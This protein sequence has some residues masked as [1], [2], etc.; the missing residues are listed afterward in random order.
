MEVELALRQSL[1][2]IL[3]WE[4]PR[5]GSESKITDVT[6]HA[7]LSAINRRI[8]N[9]DDTVVANKAMGTTLR[10]AGCKSQPEY[11]IR[12]ISH[13]SDIL[14]GSEA[15]GTENS[16]FSALIQ[17]L[18]LCG[19]S[20]L[21][22][23]ERG[24][25]R[26]DCAV[27]GIVSCWDCLQVCAVYLM[28]DSF[29]VIIW[30]SPPLMIACLQDRIDLA[31][32]VI[33]LADF[34]AKTIDLLKTSTLVAAEEVN[35]KLSSKIFFKKVR[36]WAAPKN[37]EHV[38]VVGH[39]STAHFGLDMMMRVYQ[40]LAD[41]EGAEKYILFPCGIIGNPTAR[42]DEYSKGIRLAIQKCQHDYF[43][44]IKLDDFRPC[45]VFEELSKG[46]G[47]STGRP[48]SHLV[49]AYLEKLLLAVEV[50]NYAE[51]AHLDL[52]PANIIW[53]ETTI[54]SEIELRII[55]FESSV[56]FGVAINYPQTLRYDS[57]YPVLFTDDRSFIP[58]FAAHNSW[59]LSAITAW[60]RDA[61]SNDS[62][63]N[64]MDTNFT[65]FENEFRNE[66][67]S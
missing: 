8:K 61:P 67:L 29:P 32:W 26:A 18:Q 46:D 27:P 45:V 41:I 58:A 53:K 30:L 7:F 17:C 48:P 59:F 15:K 9:G 10:M 43:G 54:E 35:I 36:E 52:R 64:Y 4:L 50:L 6:L 38:D 16:S 2:T 51:I 3:S 39:G 25:T 60:L 44:G 57:R 11:R 55:D 66:L 14:L 13:S 31:R 42:A 23:L 1:R 21:H 49:G 5:G 63:R 12:R 37:G 24:L 33:S 62:F 34:A 40:R 22:L 65:T 56:P 19:D 47:W 20:A 28:P